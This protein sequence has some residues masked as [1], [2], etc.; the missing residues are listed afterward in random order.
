MS[1]ADR[2][3]AH[4]PPRH[5]DPFCL[6]SETDSRF[7]LLVLTIAGITLNL[8]AIL[9]VAVTKTE[10]VF[11]EFAGAVAL[12][13]IVFGWAWFSAHRQ[14]ARQVARDQL[15]PFPP[16]GVS[17]DEE[18]SLGQLAKYIQRTVRLIPELEDAPVQ[19][20]W[21]P[22]SWLASGVAF[23]FGKRPYVC[24]RQ[25]LLLQ[26][27]KRE[28]ETFRAVLLHELAHVANRDVAKTTFSIQLGRCFYWT[29][30]AVL[31]I[32]NG[33][34]VRRLLSTWAAGSSWTTIGDILWLAAKIN[35]KSLIAMLLVEVIRGSVLRVRE[36][37]A[38]ARASTWMGRAGP[39]LTLLQPAP[40]EADPPPKL[41]KPWTWAWQQFRT[42]LVPLHPTNEDRCAA[43]INRRWLFRP[44]REVAL[45]AGLLTGLA[46]NS[47]FLAFTALLGLT[48]WI[49]RYTGHSLG[50]SGSTGLLLLAVVLMGFAF[51]LMFLGQVVLC[52]AFAVLPLAGTLGVQVQRAAITDRIQPSAAKLLS[53]SKIAGLAYTAGGGI[54][55][56]FWLTP[57]E[58]VLSL[59]GRALGMA[60]IY[61][62]GW[63][64]VLALWLALLRHLSSRF[65]GDHTG[66]DFPRRKRRL[67]SLISTGALIPT[68]LVMT[69][70][71][72][73]LTPMVLGFAGLD[74]ANQGAPALVRGVIGA[75]WLISP[76][77]ASGI[78]GLGWLRLFRL[79]TKTTGQRGTDWAWTPHA[80]PRPRQPS[81]PPLPHEQA[82]SVAP[83]L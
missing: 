48:D 33:M 35:F 40:R 55:L 32:M 59:T 22:K 69:L 3:A 8:G 29:T 37:Y 81:L 67:L 82:P 39:L 15:V 54:L 64:A 27:V 74:P 80:I 50:N 61:F 1:T 2:G 20:V 10:S 21:D 75:A 23:G 53:F 41:H 7:L 12:T 14:A 65:L 66:P 49:S 79:D 56:G 25:G 72:A 18:K 28:I 26:F 9:T 44:S 16:A 11:L 73:L 17:P 60:P 34:V 77:L 43:L 63:S 38:D 30:F 70:T 24:L 62:I 6:P 57:L 19:F 46:L 4:L 68:L 36:H 58:N 78:W 31:L 42:H 51:L 52:T 45:F 5:P 13:L 71:Q 83:P 76:V 47:N